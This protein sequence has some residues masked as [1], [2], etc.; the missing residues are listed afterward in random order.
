MNAENAFSLQNSF[1]KPTRGKF[2]QNDEMDMKELITLLNHYFAFLLIL[3]NA[4]HPFQM[5]CNSS[6]NVR[7]K[8][9]ER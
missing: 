1:E 9:M 6:G 8:R 5:Q 7:K 3:D 2:P 4:D